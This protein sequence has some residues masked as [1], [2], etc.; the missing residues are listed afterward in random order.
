VTAALVS[1]VIPFYNAKA[2]LGDAVESVLAQGYRPLEVCL[3]DDASTD[4]GAGAAARL[5]EAS[6]A[7]RLFR[8]ATNQGP[9]AARNAGLH[10]ARG[11]LV[12]F[13]DADDLMVPDRVAVQAAYLAAHPEADVV[14]GLADNVLEP[15]VAP[16]SWLPHVGTGVRRGY[17]YA[18][19]MLAR[20]S[21][22]ARV[23]LFDPTLRVSEDTEWM[24]RAR[25]AG[26]VI[27]RIDR[28]LIRRRLH[29]ANLSYRTEEM[30]AAVHRIL[31]RLARARIAER[32]H[33]P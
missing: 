27:A 15:G 4:G 19:T 32:R 8:L 21:V 6:P 13:L 33:V 17:A 7:V 25:A 14:V 31:L 12:T 9:A 22:F 10:A 1:V 23:G 16:P 24:L 20:R 3:V 30:R 5:A 28:A 2:F 11:D 18:M 26:V 29:G